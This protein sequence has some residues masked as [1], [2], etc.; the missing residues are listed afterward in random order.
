MTQPTVHSTV[1]FVHKACLTMKS[2]NNIV[3]LYNDS[4]YCLLVKTTKS[5]NWSNGGEDE[6]PVGYF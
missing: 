2:L 4:A 1:W 5:R 3:L 6:G